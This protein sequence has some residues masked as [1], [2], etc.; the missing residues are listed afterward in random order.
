MK[1]ARKQIPA[2]EVPERIA[3]KVTNQVF[4]ENLLS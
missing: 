2:Y 3:K 1:K 4:T